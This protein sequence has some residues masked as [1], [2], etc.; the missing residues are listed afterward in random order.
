MTWPAKRSSTSSP[1]SVSGNELRFRRGR[2][3]HVQAAVPERFLELL[4]RGVA[5]ARQLR[6]P[7]QSR[8]ST[9]PD[10]H[11]RLIRKPADAPHQRSGEPENILIDVEPL[12]TD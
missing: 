4:I 12:Q 3:L 2:P 1:T 5:Q 10:C 9:H 8:S 6:E 7:L 11:R